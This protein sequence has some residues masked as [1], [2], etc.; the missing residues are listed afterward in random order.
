MKKDFFLFPAHSTLARRGLAAVLSVFLAGNSVGSSVVE[1]SFWKE[2]R[3]ATLTRA[4]T[5]PQSIALLASSAGFSA[6]GPSS[7]LADQAF[8]ALSLE[9]TPFRVTRGPRGRIPEP[10]SPSLAKILQSLPSE[11][12]SVRSISLPPGPSHRIVV[13]IQDIH[14]NIEAQTHISG[15]VGRLLSSGAVEL[16]GLEGA[17]A[18]LDLKP[19]QRFP[20]RDTMRIVAN[21]LLARHVISG[22]IHGGMLLEKSSAPFVGVDDEIHHRLNV[23]AYRHSLK[24]HAKAIKFLEAADRKLETQKEIIF[25]PA[26]QTFDRAL[27]AYREGQVV[28]ADHVKT[29]AAH[30][31]PLPPQLRLFQ[32]A[33]ILEK[34]INFRKA[35]EERTEVLEQLVERLA[36]NEVSDLASQ[37]AAFKTG[38]LSQGSFYAYL[39]HLCESNGLAWES[40][41]ALHQ[42]VAY[43]LMVQSLRMEQLQEELSQTATAVANRLAVRP[44]EKILLEDSER[45][46]LLTA[47]MNFTLTSNEW[48]EY[49][50]QRF[51][52]ASMP[53]AP[54]QRAIYESFYR[55]AEKRDKAMADR[56]LESMGKAQCQTAV[57]VAGG[58]HG[59]GIK[60]LLMAQGTTVVDFVP[61][62]TKIEAESGSAYLSVFN[63]EKTPL[64]QLFSAEK[65]FVAK[66]PMAPT[67]AF[68]ATG[69]TA[70]VE[71]S[72]IGGVS[73][74][75]IVNAF[76]SD[77]FRLR[78]KNITTTFKEGISSVVFHFADHAYEFTYTNGKGKQEF[79][80]RPVLSKSEYRTQMAREA[81]FFLGLPAGVILGH[82]VGISMGLSGGPL[83]LFQWTGGLALLGVCVARLDSLHREGA[84]L[85]LQAIGITRSFKEYKQDVRLVLFG[86]ALSSLTLFTVVMKV[87]SLL[88]PGDE[89]FLAPL[90]TGILSAIVGALVTHPKLNQ[91]MIVHKRSH[92]MARPVIE[93]ELIA[94]G[95]SPQKQVSSE[96]ALQLG[97]EM[98]SKGNLDLSPLWRVWDEKMEK[99]DVFRYSLA[100]MKKRLLTRFQAV[101]NP[102]RAGKR[103]AQMQTARVLTPFNPLGF[104]FDN[105]NFNPNEILAENVELNGEGDPISVDVIAN[106]NPLEPRHVLFT[107]ER[108][109]RHSQQLTPLAVKTALRLLDGK[110]GDQL[111]V[112]YN[113]VGA[114]AS[115]PHLH[116]QGI[117]SDSLPVE[118]AFDGSEKE[119]LS[120][121]D[122][123]K[124]W[125]FLDWPIPCFVVTG[126]SE[127]TMV[128]AA[129][130]LAESFQNKNQPFNALF[131]RG[132]PGEGK[133]IFL[134][135]RK[136]EGPTKSGTGIAWYECT[137]CALFAPVGER[138]VVQSEAAFNAATDE[139]IAEEMAEYALSPED[140]E[141]YQANILN[142]T[143]SESLT[144]GGL[145]LINSPLPNT[146]ERFWT[147]WNK[148]LNS[149]R[150]Y[151]TRNWRDLV[152][153]AS[154]IGFDT[155]RSREAQ[156]LLKKNKTFERD[157][158]ENGLPQVDL[159]AQGAIGFAQEILTTHFEKVRSM[160]IAQG[161]PEGKPYFPYLYESRD[162]EFIIESD[163][164]KIVLVDVAERAAYDPPLPL[165]DFTPPPRDIR[166]A[167]PDGKCLFCRLLNNNSPEFFASIH[168]TGNNV[169]RTAINLGE[170]GYPH[171]QFIA[172]DPVPNLYDRDNRFLDFLLSARA[173]GPEFD[174]MI[175][176]AF[177]GASQRHLHWH[178]MKRKEGGLWAYVDSLSP[179]KGGGTFVRE[180]LENYPGRPIVF[181][182]KS[183]DR[184]A[185]TIVQE[186]RDLYDNKI[187]AGVFARVHLDGRY[188]VV[189]APTRGERM[190]SW[191]IIFNGSD[192]EFEKNRRTVRNFNLSGETDPT[193]NPLTDGMGA[194]HTP[195]AV[196][197]VNFEIPEGFRKN[198]EWQTRTA[199]RLILLFGDFNPKLLNPIP[200][201]PSSAP[202]GQTLLTRPVQNSPVR[203]VGFFPSFS[204]RKFYVGVPA[205]FGKGNADV[206]RL[207]L[208]AAR[209]LNM[210][211]PDGQPDPSKLSMQNLPAGEGKPGAVFRDFVLFNLALETLFRTEAAQRGIPY[212][213]EAYAGVSA[214]LIV[215]SA[216]SGSLSVPDMVKVADF[217]WRN[218][219][220]EGRAVWREKVQH[221]AVFVENAEKYRQWLGE[222]D[223]KNDVH[224]YHFVSP[225]HIQV[226]VPVSFV[227]A[228]E[229]FNRSLH[230]VRIEPIRGPTLEIAHSPKLGSARE[231][232]DEFLRREGILFH[233]PAIPILSNNG[234]QFLHTAEEVKSAILAIIDEPMH[235]A[236]TVKNLTALHPD[237]MIEFGLGERGQQ[238]L[239]FNGSPILVHPGGPDPDTFK[240]LFHLMSSR[241]MTHDRARGSFP[242]AQTPL[243]K[244]VWRFVARGL[245]ISPTSHSSRQ[246]ELTFT[247]FWEFTLHWVAPFFLVSWMLAY[248]GVPLPD[249][250]LIPFLAVILEQAFVGSH[251]ISDQGKELFWLGH[252]LMVFYG[253]GGF[254]MAWGG[255]GIAVGAA[256]VVV[257][258]RTHYLHDMSRAPP[259]SPLGQGQGQNDTSRVLTEEIVLRD[260]LDLPTPVDAN[261]R[262]ATARFRFVGSLDETVVRDHSAVTSKNLL[263]SLMDAYAKGGDG[264]AGDLGQVVKEENAGV[265]V[266]PVG[267]DRKG[268]GALARAC[269]ASRDRDTEIRF[270]A[271]N[272][273][274]AIALSFW[275]VGRSRVQVRT[276]PRAFSLGS[277]DRRVVRLLAVQEALAKDVALRS[278]KIWRIVAPESIAM[279][280]SGL[281]ESSPLWSASIVFLDAL[282]R[283]LPVPVGQL[284]DLDSAASRLIKR[285]A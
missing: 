257:G 282:L 109:Q 145:L 182:G 181:R 47:L 249:M 141:P 3:K 234:G 55:E 149:F 118:N 99:G 244:S 124:V 219:L 84:R 188:E 140:L 280:Y 198:S 229:E 153:K 232:L 277:G 70:V 48:V 90:A 274:V 54:S 163:G 241:S 256:M 102:D 123:V 154:Q 18:P 92:G 226:I 259:P 160:L 44:E 21:D 262:S 132:P 39:K 76:L 155:W 152:Q 62:I 110:G 238:I 183:P 158:M 15:A 168:G 128:E 221:Y 79:G 64:D 135:P 151:L 279:D 165:F 253:F 63:Q 167:H 224:I 250:W 162:R 150:I 185:E 267:A 105:K 208:E 243:T 199:K 129:V 272:T 200:D 197:N 147:V 161:R 248:V 10:L 30:T 81:I 184:L 251:S 237:L 164:I 8:D 9:T 20:S 216:A 133:R 11:F 201:V 207:Y 66:A 130:S 176:G 156:E 260:I 87:I 214:G 88:A 223:L 2:R 139:S 137:G 284:R 80:Q 265:W 65:L 40:Y 138:T 98:L 107:P 34:E 57:L 174:V 114:F 16:V 204:A 264:W 112:G 172:E 245:G 45:L 19:Y 211:G 209:A 258:L 131:A 12:G 266:V 235:T 213:M 136:V 59:T 23:E 13:H 231:K 113:S 1:G 239:Q 170:Y 120:E 192:D 202:S 27:R 210:V 101:F 283:S 127:A 61:R 41:S 121:S 261:L 106:I 26:L 273:A 82:L 255:G 51:S 33:V 69:K 285:M 52:T 22:P 227:S 68:E 71:Q 212:K 60:K 85:A 100:K 31:A 175:N 179:P 67:A 29:L 218:V 263:L 83:F 254:L 252:F 143:K 46:H 77:R 178:G 42:Y 281:P 108:A 117:L 222:S 142:R 236:G 24:N 7:L 268:V 166:E 116:L 38:R 96:E 240:S 126:D 246:M 144:T 276:A 56:L 215:A 206:D 230:A 180:E 217:F 104:H 194:T 49:K 86:S 111:K 43:V 169:Y 50:A 4:K 275:S 94:A 37:S 157:K 203:V 159:R 205:L 78:I 269:L 247:V 190:V 6:M 97:R 228:F 171:F 95:S 36:E 53:L 17:F 32:K 5:P 25:S 125:K 119:M 74:G 93:H 220:Q 146:I 73:A 89:F 189:V 134:F 115:I 196:P 191:D 148:L 72:K 103:P 28:L 193:F 195:G 58:F 91:F 35:E 14:E 233:D 122:G 186:I 242:L 177:S 187:S 270:V 173:L 225:F 75:S 278:G 271:E